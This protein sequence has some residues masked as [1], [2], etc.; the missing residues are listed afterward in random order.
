MRSAPLATVRH[1]IVLG[2]PLPFNV[3][4]EDDSLLLARGLPVDSREHVDAL[5]ARGV[6]VNLDEVLDPVD[7]ARRAPAEMLPRVWQEVQ[8]QIVSTMRQRAAADLEARLQQ[9]TAPLATLIKRDPDVAIFQLLVEQQDER[10]EQGIRQAIQAAVVTALIAHRLNWATDDLARATKAALTMNISVLELL[11]ATSATG[12]ASREAEGARREALLAHPLRSREMLE[13]AG[14]T[15]RDWL[16]AV[17][18]HHE[19][20]DGSGYPRG[21]RE[22][23][24][25][26]SMLRCGDALASGME[27]LRGKDRLTPN[28]LIRRIYLEE[29]GN[30][31]ARALVKEMGIYPPGSVVALA[32]GEVALVVKRG[33]SITTPIV[34]AVANR[35]RRPYNYPVHRDTSKPGFRVLTALPT[36]DFAPTPTQALMAL[37]AV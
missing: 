5:I 30:L 8:D 37:Q 34:T 12:A 11:G 2:R 20:E 6:R 10:R 25:L 26:A 21:L 28:H 31:Y 17:E 7:L 9:A 14:I 18:H 33:L 32:S 1:R 23:G 4:A 35:F 15:D 29:R 16:L 27:E 19:R 22:V 3:Y 24:E 13:A 36:Y